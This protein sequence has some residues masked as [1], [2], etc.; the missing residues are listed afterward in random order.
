MPEI[1]EYVETLTRAAY[2]K[3]SAD[4]QDIMPRDRQFH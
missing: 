1:A 4:I 3:A 2:P